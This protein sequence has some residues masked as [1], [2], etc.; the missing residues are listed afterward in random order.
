MTLAPLKLPQ[1]E[2]WAPKV[3]QQQEQP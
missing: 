3:Q 2:K 1:S